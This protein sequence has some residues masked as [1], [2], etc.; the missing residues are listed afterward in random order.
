MHDQEP[1]PDKDAYARLHF[2]ALLGFGVSVGLGLVVA[3]DVITRLYRGEAVPDQD[4]QGMYL[5]IIGIIASGSLALVT[6]PEEDE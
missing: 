6:A 4:A 2:F 5:A 1:R 3:L